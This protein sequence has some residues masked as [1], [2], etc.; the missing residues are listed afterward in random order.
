MKPRALIV[1]LVIVTTSACVALANETPVQDQTDNEE[2]KRL[3]DEDQSDRRPEAGKPIDWS[4]IG[5]RDHEREQRVKELLANGA[6][7]TGA[8]FFHAAMVLQHAIEPDDYLLCHDLC[9]IAI[10]K[11]EMRAKWLAAASMDRFLVSVGRLQRFGTQF[12]GN[13]PGMPPQLRPVDPQVS[14][15]LR[16]EFN[17]PPLAKAKERETM[18][19][20]QF[21]SQKKPSL[22]E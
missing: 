19:R 13:R 10:A 22:K 17:V 2:L 1:A 9:I 5:P 4:L 6:L 3:F 14:D 8:D 12:G 7:Q 15:E 11:G 20:E 18:M 21:E 16:R